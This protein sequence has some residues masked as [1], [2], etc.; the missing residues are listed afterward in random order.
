MEDLLKNNEIKRIDKR[1][2]YAMANYGH[3]PTEELNLE[4]Y[5]H[6]TISDSIKIDYHRGVCIGYRNLALHYIIS[7]SSIDAFEILQ[8]IERLIKTYDL[9]DEDTLDLYSAYIIYYIE[10][11]GDLVMGTKYAQKGLELAE[12]L[13]NKN[14]IMR[15]KSN[16]AVINIRLGYL[17]NAR[18]MLETTLEYYESISDEYHSMYVYN[19]LAEVY[20]NLNLL[21]KSKSYYQKAL[22]HSKDKDEVTIIIDSSNGLSQ[23]L[24]KE[25]HFID[26]IELLEDVIEYLKA[27][28]NVKFEIEANIQLANIYVLQGI[29]EAAFKVL[30]SIEE[31]IDQI[32]NQT[33]LIRFYKLYADV[34]KN[35]EQ[36]Q[37]AYYALDKYHEYFIKLNDIK[38]ER[39]I[40]EVMK[41]E[42]QKTVVRLETIATVGRE[43]TTLSNVDEVLFE[44]KDILSSLMD[45]NGI[46]IGELRGDHIEFNHFLVEGLKMD[47]T[48]VTLD[49]E[50]SLAVWSVN[51]N[52]EVQV[53]DL[54]NDYGLYVKTIARNKVVSD[55]DNRKETTKSVL[56]APLV[57]KGETIGVFTIQSFKKNAFLTEEFEVFRII[58]AYVAI[59]FKNVSQS[60]ILEE[61]SIKDSLTGINNRRGFTEFYNNITQEKQDLSTVAIIM[62]DLDYFKKIN[63]NYSHVAGDEVLIQVAKVLMDMEGQLI[64]SAR[65]GGEEFGF[66]IFNE[67]EDFAIAFAEQVRTRIEE[68]NVIYDRHNIKV[69]ASLGV[70]FEVYNSET[71][72]KQLYYQADK[73]M[74]VA[75]SSGRNNIKINKNN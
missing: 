30:N 38:G 29:N 63:D 64:I 5:I 50:S 16:L 36:Y 62:L 7:D 13:N 25:K 53:N 60:M 73:A 26:A 67:S 17:E 66:V 48:S 54:D 51:N 74:L 22:K 68:L 45:I 27:S 56:Y 37:I 18:E 40:N 41:K 42:Y 15:L 33:V 3:L 69:T 75:K 55:A 70:S 19:N 28:K 1:N 12:K 20:L 59:A 8:K 35:L 24:A 6:K 9:E 32:E 47:A 14:M 58:V 11:V 43:L 49:N 4:K 57:V 71:D 31:K 46:G 65:L 72:F 10:Y 52:K 23:I 34:S 2:N 21:S 39:A 44:V 61:Q